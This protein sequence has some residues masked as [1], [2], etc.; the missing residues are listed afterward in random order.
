MQAVPGI[1]QHGQDTVQGCLLLGVPP[2]L[3]ETRRDIWQAVAKL[4]QRKTYL[5][6]GLYRPILIAREMI[7]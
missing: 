7:F 3:M 6:A 5:S 4:G 1:S 2:G